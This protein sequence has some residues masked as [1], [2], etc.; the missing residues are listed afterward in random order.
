[1]EKRLWVEKYLDENVKQKLTLTHN[2]HL[3]KGDIIID[4]TTSHGVDKFEGEH[5]HFGQSQFPDWNSVLNHL[6]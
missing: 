6:L 4:D 5:I 3:F 2:K 1:M